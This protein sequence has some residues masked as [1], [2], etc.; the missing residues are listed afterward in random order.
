MPRYV[1][2]DIRKVIEAQAVLQGPPKFAVQ[3]DQ[4]TVERAFRNAER[5]LKEVD[6]KD[7]RRGALLGMLGAMV[8]NLLLLAVLLLV[9]LRW[10]GMI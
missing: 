7:R 3:I 6:A 2:R 8:F 5:W 4:N 9:L 10:R 1:Q